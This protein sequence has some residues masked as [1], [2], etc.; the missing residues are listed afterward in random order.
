M[1]DKLIEGIKEKA[2]TGV[3]V[4][5]SI[6]FLWGLREL[7]KGLYEK[8]E[9]IVID[10]LGKRE[11]L[12]TLIM[13]IA[14]IIFLSIILLK[15]KDMKLQ[16]GIYWDK[17]KNPHCPSCKK[18]LGSYGEYQLGSGFYCQSCNTIQPMSN[19]GVALTTVQA[20]AVMDKM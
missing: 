12:I 2:I 19:R 14:I 11:L 5:I 9:P 20:L 13:L 8:I 7:T 15:K 18:P 4:G 1:M 3:I 17:D 10:H 16:Y 6:F